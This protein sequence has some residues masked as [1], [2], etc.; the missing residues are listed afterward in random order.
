MVSSITRIKVKLELNCQLEKKRSDEI[1]N[2]AKCMTIRSFSLIAHEILD[3][4]EITSSTFLKCT[5][6]AINFFL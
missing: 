5:R 4:R 1:K 3:Y 6:F 2:V